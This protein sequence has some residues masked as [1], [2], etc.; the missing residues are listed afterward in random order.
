MV[1]HVQVLQA[2]AFLQCGSGVAHLQSAGL[3]PGEH[4]VAGARAHAASPPPA[5]HGAG[6]RHPTLLQPGYATL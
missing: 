5:L 3:A 2:K 1:L 6:R 4:L